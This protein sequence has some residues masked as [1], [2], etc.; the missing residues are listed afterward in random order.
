MGGCARSF[1]TP[2][3]HEHACLR[4]PM[5]NVNPKMLP[6]LASTR[7]RPISWIAGPVPSRRAGSE[8][9][10]GSTSP[11]PSSVRNAKRASGWLASRRS[12][13]ACRVSGPGS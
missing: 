6:R 5:L 13:S 4:C 9:S 1:G 7:S 8:R 3:Q 2:C 12:T 10:R 11:S